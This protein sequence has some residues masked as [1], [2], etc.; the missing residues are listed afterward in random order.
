MCW[1][2]LHKLFYYNNLLNIWFETTKEAVCI[3]NID[4]FQNPRNL[5]DW[6][7]FK[8][9]LLIWP[10]WDKHN[11]FISK[12]VKDTS[13][14]HCLDTQWSYIV[15]SSEWLL[16]IATFYFLGHTEY[17][18]NKICQ[19]KLPGFLQQTSALQTYTM[20]FVSGTLVISG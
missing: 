11:L 8:L 19:S 17:S 14:P 15:C 20:I 10:V 16:A 7:L 18:D 4:N 3:S 6:F 5:L 13:L 2:W 9:K 12:R 1:L